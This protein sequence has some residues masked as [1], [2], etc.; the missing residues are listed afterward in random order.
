MPDHTNPAIVFRLSPGK[1]PRIGSINIRMKPLK[2]IAVFG[3][4]MPAP[5]EPDYADA[6]AVGYALGEAG[7]AVMTGGYM[8]VME[9]AS[10]G[11]AEAG[12]HVIGVTCEQIEA[13]RPA[14]AN[15]WVKEEILYPTLQERVD[16]LVI[17]A[18]GY[19]VMS[20]GVGTLVEM[21]TAWE[22]MRIDN[23]PHHP[24]I[25]YGPF[26]NDLMQG[27]I[28]SSYVPERHKQMIHFV[29]TPEQLV[30]ILKNGVHP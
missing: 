23:I 20:G 13:I 10:R 12:A 7:F 22:M 4:S 15:R 27:L 29:D 18:D 9:A 1:I 6:Q 17:H 21:A 3:S 24:I 26:W 16:H 2:T 8:G 30:Q 19:V 11:A 5:G 25:C 14:K 28:A